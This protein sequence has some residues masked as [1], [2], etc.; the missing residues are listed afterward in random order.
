MK[1]SG[2][3]ISYKIEGKGRPIFCIHGWGGDKHSFDDLIAGFD[4]KK[5]QVIILDM[6]GFGES[7]VPNKPFTLDDYANLFVEFVDEIRKKYRISGTYSLIVHS[8][9]GRVA[10]KLS[11][12]IGLEDVSHLVLIA[13]AGIKHPPTFKK[14]FG[15]IV[16]SLGACFKEIKLTKKMYNFLRKLFYK[17]IR[18]HDYEDLSKSMKQT[19][20]NV[21]EEDM[22]PFLNTITCKTLIIWGDK[23]TYVPVSDAYEM[24]ESI[25]ASQLI[26]IEGGRHGIHHTHAS[27]LSRYI[28]SFLS[29]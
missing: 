27:E 12:L 22:H 7:S 23:D 9:G 26:V 28:S 24:H 13:A 18:E 14:R 19:F 2:L 25:K 6:P 3:K 8:F 4:I 29:K 17:V 11:E 21:I 20:C 5:Y 1:L 10:F 16:A 15:K